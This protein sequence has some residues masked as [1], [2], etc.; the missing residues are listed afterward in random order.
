M[1]AL[2]NPATWLA[3]YIPD[4]PTPFDVNGA[5]DLTAFERL[6]ERQIRAGVSAIVAGETTGEASTLTPAEHETIVRA[7]VGIARGRVR[8][9]AGAGSNSTSQAI[10]LTRRAD[11]AG[12][13]A[14]LSVVPYYNKPMQAGIDAHFQAIAGSTTLPVILHDIPSRTIRELADD[15]L[16]RLAGS[17]QFIGL[18]DG[19]G[20]ITR[21][22]R[23][24]PR[25]PH[26]LRLLSG[27]D[28]TAPAFIANGGDGCI[29]TISNVAPEL[30]LA[31]FSSCRQGRLQTA[32]YLDDRLAP[33]TA[34]LSKES[35]AAL[36][37][38]L[39]LLGFMSPTTRLPI[40]E[41]ADSAKAEVAGAIAEI[42]D[43]DL[44]CPIESW[45]SQPRRDPA[46]RRSRHPE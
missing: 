23:L 19:T 39:C 9:I 6:C 7:A 12:A 46:A 1:A 25:L 38:A 24:R 28:A 30:C 31:I 18:R 15:T 5:I 22:L 27:D 3:G 8:V 26:G 16:T 20:D 10:E 29:S 4:L 41:L 36:K 34:A 2:A 17:K 13:D 11:A 37:Y 35:P 44:A 21:L 40:V 43:E 14:I 45:R 32:R 33:L 42:G